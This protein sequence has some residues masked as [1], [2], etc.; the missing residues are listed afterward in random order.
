MPSPQDTWTPIPV[1]QPLDE[2]LTPARVGGGG[3]TDCLNLS[4]HRTAAWGKRSGSSLAYSVANSGAFPNSPWV[5]GVRWYRAYPTPLTKIVFAA[6]GSLWE[7][8]DIGSTPTK[9]LDFEE[10][11]PE[12]I[13]FCSARDP[14]AMDGNGSDILIIC[15]GKTKLSFA[16]NFI[17]ITT[18]G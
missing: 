1:G 3:L 12:P 15:G 7:A 14:N 11:P 2:S 4:Y 13:Q 10:A 16:T 5:S 18:T 9:L 6:G 17:L 8:D